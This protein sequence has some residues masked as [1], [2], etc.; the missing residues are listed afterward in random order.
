MLF[1][2]MIE[3]S[4]F[5]R[6]IEQYRQEVEVLVKD[7]MARFGVNLIV[8]IS[9]SAEKHS[10]SIAKMH[11]YQLVEGLKHEACAILTGG[12][13]DGVPELGVKAA[14]EYHLPT[15]GVFPAAGRKYALL[16][17]LDLAIQS[18]PPSLG[19][20]GFGTETPSFAN[21]PDFAVVIGGG[22]GTLIEI[23]TML[24]LNTKRIR[25]ALPI[26][27][28]PIHNSGGVADL[29]PSLVKLTPEIDACLPKQQFNTG[30]EIAQYIRNNYGNRGRN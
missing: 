21:L 20:A 23:A 11:V 26:V 14:K 6:A 3:N 27:I 8:S 30:A 22:Q 7:F 19:P 25:D 9:G 12:T 1:C 5:N 18:L 15:I 24:K 13:K 2:N 10:E 16:E 17:D 4:E 29:V 28:C